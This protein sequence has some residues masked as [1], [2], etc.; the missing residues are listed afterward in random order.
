MPKTYSALIRL[1]TFEERYEYLRLGGAVGAATFGFERYLNQSLYRSREWHRARNAAIV[2]DQGRD[3]AVP[4]REVHGQITVHHINP[5][6]AEG[7]G[8][9]DGYIFDLENLVCA[10]HATHNAI[11]YGDASLLP[12]LPPERKK[13]DTLL[14]P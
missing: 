2:R 5:L 7:V 8:R 1:P 6:S 13:G 3:L 4:G 10:S 14:W 12:G 9:G 11:H